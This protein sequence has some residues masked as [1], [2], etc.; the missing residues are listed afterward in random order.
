MNKEFDNNIIKDKKFSYVFC[1]NMSL[2][3]HVY[4][5]TFC[6]IWK[7]YEWMCNVV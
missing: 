4:W 3:W 7:P 5:F 2:H 6:V 1:M